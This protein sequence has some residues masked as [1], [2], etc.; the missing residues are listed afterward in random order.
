VS[1]GRCSCCG[2]LVVA[3]TVSTTPRREKKKL[4]EQPRLVAGF[5]APKAAKTAEVVSGRLYKKKKKKKKKKK[6]Q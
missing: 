3:R 5:K 2:P 6:N 1:C 4:N